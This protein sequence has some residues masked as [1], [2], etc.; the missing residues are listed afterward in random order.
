MVIPYELEEFLKQNVGDN[1]PKSI[2]LELPIQWIIEN[3]VLIERSNEAYQREQ[4]ANT[5]FNEGIVKTILDESFIKIPEVH[6]SVEMSDDGSFNMK[7]DVDD[8][9]WIELIA[10]YELMDG[11]QRL[12]AIIKFLTNEVAVPTTV[13]NDNKHLV[14]KYWK[15]LKKIKGIGSKILN[16]PVGV[17]FYIN[18]NSSIKAHLFTEVL[19]QVTTM[20]PQEIR[21]AIEGAYS[22]YVRSVSRTNSDDLHLLFERSLVAKSNKKGNSLKFDRYGLRWFSKSFALNNRMEVDEWVSQLAYLYFNGYRKGVSHHKHTKWVK[23]IQLGSSDPKAKSYRD[24]FTDRKKIDKLLDFSFEL[25]QEANKAGNKKKMTSMVAMIMT[26]YADELRTR[27][28]RL[29]VSSFVNKFFKV[30][31]EWSDTTKKLYN[32]RT[33]IDSDAQMPPFDCLFGGKNATAIGTICQILD[34]EL[35]KDPKSFGAIKLDER[36][37]FSKLDIEKKWKDQ[38]KKCFY[39][40]NPISLENAVG[41]GS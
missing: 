35:D 1:T 13:S 3:E 12:T 8:I 37:V 4:V 24:R 39:T 9:K 22:N 14:G 38:G 5:E 29:I 33:I 30:Y 10:G 11:Q 21:N 32:D 27:Y 25:V 40:N 23:S 2:R 17:V 18:I 6:M 16:Y 31:E 36:E 41:D 34:E 7:C 26:L 15:D 20:K 28:G 19:N